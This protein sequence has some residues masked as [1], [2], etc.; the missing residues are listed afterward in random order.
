M[1]FGDPVPQETVRSQFV[2]RSVG[3]GSQTWKTWLHFKIHSF[4]CYFEFLESDS[5]PVKV[6]MEANFILYSG[7]VLDLSQ[8]IYYFQFRLR[9]I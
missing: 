7:M 2:Y 3:T 5:L 8:G 4:A 1:E 6:V 9:V